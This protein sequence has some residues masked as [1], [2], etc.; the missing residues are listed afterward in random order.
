M[1]A[2]IVTS[3]ENLF[4][5]DWL[6][7]RKKGIGGSDASVVCGINRYK[8]QVELWMEKTNHMPPQEV[9]ESA[10]WVTVL[11]QNVKREFTKR[12]K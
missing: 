1:A 2:K 8:S 9:G 3:T 5:E 11:E 12:T 4:C 10:Y 6:D 7:F